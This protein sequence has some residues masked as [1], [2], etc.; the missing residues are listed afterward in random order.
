[1]AKF[2][3]LIP[4]NVMDKM[5]AGQELTRED[6]ITTTGTLC[7]FCGKEV[8]TKKRVSDREETSAEDLL[9]AEVIVHV[10]DKGEYGCD[11]HYYHGPCYWKEA[12]EQDAAEE[13]AA[14][15]GCSTGD[16]ELLN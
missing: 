12:E 5:M 15:D 10:T 4:R 9:N 6:T 11:N 14:S 16:V 1:M 13:R 2:G 7:D 8:D 3:M